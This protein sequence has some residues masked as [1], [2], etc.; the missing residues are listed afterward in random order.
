MIKQFENF[1]MDKPIYTL[2][3]KTFNYYV[4]DE[5]EIIDLVKEYYKTN[6]TNIDYIMNDTDFD[7][8]IKREDGV[9]YF[10]VH[11]SNNRHHRNIQIKKTNSLESY[12]KE[13][14]KKKFNL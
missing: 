11:V 4:T 2:D 5:T 9:D 6:K 7:L 12:K 1:N 13:Q 14:T 10:V 3:I 8:S